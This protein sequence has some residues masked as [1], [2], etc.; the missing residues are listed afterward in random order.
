MLLIISTT[1][2]GSEHTAILSISLLEMLP[3]M[4]IFAKQ[5]VFQTSVFVHNM[6]WRGIE[7]LPDL[8]LNLRIDQG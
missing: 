7:T 2:R 3:F 5:W 8:S 4:A 6:T 1:K